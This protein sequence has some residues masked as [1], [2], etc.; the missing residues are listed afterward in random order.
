MKK[1][2]L[3]ILPF[4]LLSSLAWA[5]SE[6]PECEGSPATDDILS[7]KEWANCYGTFIFPDGAKY[8]GEFKDGKPHGQG[9]MTSSDGTKYVG[10]FKDG[11][12]HGKGFYTRPGGPTF[13]GIWKD[14]EL[15]EMQ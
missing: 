6:L 5:E 3:Y 15:I 4:L 12:P 2:F 10:E 8:V 7:T 11:Q 1:L 14:G 9:T 13:N